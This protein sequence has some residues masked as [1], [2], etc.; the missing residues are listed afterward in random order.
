MNE[1]MN[2]YTDMGLAHAELPLGTCL[3]KENRPGNKNLLLSV[4]L[5]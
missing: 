3:R 5:L 2:F 1:W 4:R